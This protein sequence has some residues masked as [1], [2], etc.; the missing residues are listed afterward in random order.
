MRWVSLFIDRNTTVY[1]D[2]FGTEYIPLEL[3]NKI[4]AKS[5][6]LNIFRIQ[7]NECIICGFYCNAF[8]EHMLAGKILLHYTNLFSPN[9]YKKND[10]IIY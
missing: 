1:F 3:L 5:V 8:I 7:D 10:K 2:S 6:T 9:S 4:R